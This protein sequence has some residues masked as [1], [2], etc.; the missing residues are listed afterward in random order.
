MYSKR[1]VTAEYLNKSKKMPVYLIKVA[2]YIK[3]CPFRACLLGLFANRSKVVQTK[4]VKVSPSENPDNK[5]NFSIETENEARE[6]SAK[7][8]ENKKKS[9]KAEFD[10]NLGFLN[11]LAFFTLFL[12][13]FFC[14]M[15]FWI[16]AGF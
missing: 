12:I 13:I 5:P 4:L 2:N 15:A 11:S 3:N 14:D 8:E 7:E 10:S 6:R 9:E 1:F 16:L